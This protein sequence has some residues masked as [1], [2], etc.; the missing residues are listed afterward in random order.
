M[1]R[2]WLALGATVFLAAV[3]LTFVPWLRHSPPSIG[4]PPES[5]A[6]EGKALPE[7]R[8]P[9]QPEELVAVLGTQRWRHWDDVLALAVAPDGVV[10][11]VAD[12]GCLCRW[13]PDTGRLLSCFQDGR[14]HGHAVALDAQGSCLFTEGEGDVSAWTLPAGP[15]TARMHWAGGSTYCLAPSPSGRTLA[16]G[17]SKATGEG[18]I[19]LR[20]LPGGPQ[21]VVLAG[22]AQAVRCLAWSHQGDLLA[23]GS[24]DHVVRLWD[25]AGGEKAVLSGHA[26][27]ICA[28]A[29]APDGK[30]LATAA[31]EGPA[32]YLW[33]TSTG[34]RAG[35]LRKVGA[36]ARGL[37]F[38]PDSKTLAVANG[39]GEIHLWD[40]ERKTYRT[41]T[42]HVG[43][44]S[45][46][47]FTSDGRTLVSGGGD[48]SVRLWDVA[49]AKEKPITQGPG[50]R[51]LAVAYSPDG[52]TL[53]QAGEAGQVRL[54]DVTTRQER[55]LEGSRTW[56]RAVA[57][58]PDGKVLAC[59]GLDS[60]VRLYEV[61]SGKL[62]DNLQAD[63]GGLFSLCFRRDGKQLAVGGEKGVVLWE[64]GGRKQPVR[65][66]GQGNPI[67]GV[68][69]A[70][71]DRNLAAIE[72]KDP[73]GGITLWDL[74]SQKPQSFGPFTAPLRCAGLATGENILVFGG[75]DG[76]LRTFDLQ[77][78]TVRV[79]VEHAHGD[80]VEGVACGTGGRLASCDRMGSVIL[81]RNN[82][83]EKQAEWKLPGT[84]HGLAFTPDGRYLA[85][86][87]TNGTA[88]VLRLP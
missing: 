7:E 81:W 5:V 41:L 85:T 19:I 10:V 67:R 16:A 55:R 24:E 82:G 86:A 13:D 80:A 51:A 22:H 79:S 6:P 71:G 20:A 15:R 21:T 50:G 78:K 33:D 49:G 9:G 8:F 75:S 26:G 52:K 43:E 29:F 17:G 68:V 64:P 28:L 27:S 36:F 39:E 34:K 2:A 18:V 47:T 48:R 61:E 32:I 76:S 84:V 3:L 58:A 25:A 65:L 87:N 77:G 31:T 30:L 69:F 12:G 4:T 1:R 44:I 73:N 59:A 35:E 42:G 57:F 23:S 62:R 40:V 38:S 83:A 53:A 37:A 45:A 72:N 66:A 14:S 63:S 70:P 56:L 11:S 74:A 54:W 60:V 88:Y 46:L